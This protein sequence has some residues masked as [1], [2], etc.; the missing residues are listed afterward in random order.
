MKLNNAAAQYCAAAF[1]L[2]YIAVKSVK[3][4]A[5]TAVTVQKS[6]LFTF[7]GTVKIKG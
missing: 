5:H 7:L 3:F 1:I 4:Y 2:F 6:N